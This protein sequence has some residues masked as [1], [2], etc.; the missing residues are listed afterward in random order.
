MPAEPR[1]PGP[2]PADLAWADVF[3]IHLDP[4]QLA[5]ERASSVDD[6][7]RVHAVAA[8]G[9]ADAGRPLPHLERIAASFGPQ[10]DLGHIR[11]AVG[12]PAVQ[13]ATAI[14]ATAYATGDRVAFASEP[15]L[16]TA[17]H[18]AAHVVQQ[19]AG[20]HLSGG[21]GE[22]GDAYE[23]NADAVADRVVAWQSAADLLP[24]T[25]TNGVIPKTQRKDRTTSEVGTV[26]A[27]LLEI[28]PEA[29]GLVMALTDLSMAKHNAQNALAD[30]RAGRTDLPGAAR[31]I[32]AAAQRAA[33]ALRRFVESQGRVHGHGS[34]GFTDDRPT[35]A[36]P[37]DEASALQ[38]LREEALDALTNI[39]R[40]YLTL[41]EG[42]AAGRRVTTALIPGV[43]YAADPEEQ[44]ALAS[45]DGVLSP[46]ES[47]GALIGWKAPRTVDEA[48]VARFRFEACPSD[49]AG[50]RPDACNLSD[51]DRLTFRAQLRDAWRRA[52]QVFR[53]ACAPHAATL[54]K[55]IKEQRESQKLIL[56]T[57]IE[58]VTTA[59]DV[60]VPGAGTGAKL[61][62][63]LAEKA[64]GI[65][66]ENA[67]EEARVGGSHTVKMLEALDRT[68]HAVIDHAV[69]LVE[70]VEDATLKAL[71]KH[72]LVSRHQFEAKIADLV[73][74]YGQQIDPLG[75]GL[76]R[77]EAE[78]VGPGLYKSVWV[79][80]GDGR[81]LAQVRVDPGLKG[82]E[83]PDRFAFLRWIDPMFESMVDDSP[84][85]SSSKVDRLPMP[86]LTGVDV[87]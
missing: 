85:I 49:L 28:S 18:E 5:A 80:H 72:A 58:V 39:T 13:A 10:H 57:L 9:V 81:R 46:L 56:D 83:E 60:A 69:Q 52:G 68:V 73:E 45:M 44:V 42:I 64:A 63:K 74:R 12:G 59:I 16:H 20:V 30:W 23:I 70:S 29:H 4:V 75:L 43:T 1:P 76:S 47:M 3:T 77:G 41:K 2:T 26:A 86:F 66:G 38:L 19:Q 7:V 17:A 21:V 35:A 65:V 48:N 84:T 87:R 25:H 8:A 22:S 36:V 40:T 82:L 14:G 53:D 51:A 71:S 33:P 31:R 11:A 34:G 67:I 15:D 27:S 61:G 54:A 79:A 55:M 62:V 37:A 50:E 78:V 24:E 32:I 6:P